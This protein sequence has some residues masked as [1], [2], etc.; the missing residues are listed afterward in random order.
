MIS[1]QRMAVTLIS[2]CDSSRT[3]PHNL[4][5]T[6][7]LPLNLQWLRGWGLLYQESASQAQGILGPPFPGFLC[8]ELVTSQARRG[9]WRVRGREG[10]GAS[11]LGL[12]SWGQVREPGQDGGRCGRDCVRRAGERMQGGP[13][14]SKSCGAGILIQGSRRHNHSSERAGP[15]FKVSGIQ[16]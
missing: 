15:T 3:V 7:I 14:A 1:A 4:D 13:T 11:C 9:V 12:W 16:L 8:R 6:W 10:F 5:F 2:D